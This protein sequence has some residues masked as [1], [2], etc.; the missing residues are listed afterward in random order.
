MERQ[1]RP[2]GISYETLTMWLIPALL[3]GILGTLAWMGSSISDMN[4]SLAVAVSKIDDHERRIQR[5]EDHDG[6]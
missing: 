5:L 1:E 6:K 4:K 2:A 3:S